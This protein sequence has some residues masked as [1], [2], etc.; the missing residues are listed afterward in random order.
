M[1]KVCL[2]FLLCATYFF[3]IAQQKNNTEKLG[4]PGDNFNLYAALK[5]FQES[6]T[7]E[8]FEQSLNDEK[9][10]INN[11]DLNGDNKIDYIKVSDNQNGLVHN[12]VLKVAINQN[13]DQ[14]VAVFVVQKKE[15]NQVE[16]QLIGD[17]D[18]YGKDYI[19]EPNYETSNAGSGTPNPGYMAPP[20]TELNDEIIIQT[21]TP[22]QVA[23]WGLVY[24]IYTPSYVVW[25]S[26]WRWAYYPTYWHPWAPSYWHYYYG[27]HYHW[28]YFYFGNY[29]RWNYY[30]YPSWRTYYYNAGFRSHSIFV[31]TR[32][33]RGDYHKTYSRPDL[34][35]NGAAL[36]KRDFPKAPSV[37]DKLPSFDKSGS[38]IHKP[39]I[40][41]IVGPG[42][43]KP[44]IAN[45]GGKPGITKPIV[46]NPVTKP[47]ITKPIGINPVPNPIS[48]KPVTRPVITKPIGINPVPNP[49]NTKPVT[50]PVITKPITSPIT[51]KPVTSPSVSRLVQPAIK[52]IDA[53]PTTKPV[54]QPNINKLGAERNF[55]N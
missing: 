19:V 24:Y 39:S 11:L 43:T 21:T 49:I 23:G 13:Q 53:R 16:I 50:R 48:T 46:T 20:T 45:P 17:E 55:F 25:R 4:L 26:P 15:N 28:D 42:T 29:R 18:L 51:T 2:L 54:I 9:T 33:K 32:V 47:G 40:Q 8:G 34:A 6:K 41:P 36:F 30:R 1:K 12:I 7:L 52:P 31:Q 5:L 14:D 27:F 37:K 44:I 10:T 35:K 38:P 3:G 22:L